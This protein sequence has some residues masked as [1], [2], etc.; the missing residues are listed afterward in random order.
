MY[1]GMRKEVMEG[2]A[3]EVQEVRVRDAGRLCGLS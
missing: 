2:R 3:Y 1:N